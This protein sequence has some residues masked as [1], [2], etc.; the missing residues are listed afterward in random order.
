[1]FWL[2]CVV[3]CVKKVRIMSKKSHSLFSPSSIIGFIALLVV[4]IGCFFYVDMDAPPSNN[5]SGEQKNVM[6]PKMADYYDVS[7]IRYKGKKLILTKHA[8]CRMGCREIDAFEVNEILS[9]GRINQRKSQPNASPCP[10]Y[11]IE[12]ESRDGQTVRAVIAD[13]NR[14][15]KLVTV[16]DLDNHYKCSCK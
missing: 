4:A 15:V 12:G 10:K 6:T 7:D 14:D 2:F 16:I 9:N 1:M 5:Y 3:L 8:R 13:C 11:A